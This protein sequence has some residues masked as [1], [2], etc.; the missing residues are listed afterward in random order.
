MK[1]QRYATLPTAQHAG[2]TAWRGSLRQPR[3]RAATT[4][5]KRITVRA[6]EALGKRVGDRHLLATGEVADLQ[7]IRSKGGLLETP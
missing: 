4:G 3:C 5:T 6:A 2:F 1:A 7:S